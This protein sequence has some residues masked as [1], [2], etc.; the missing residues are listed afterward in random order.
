MQIWTITSVS[1]TSNSE[2]MFIGSQ[3]VLVPEDYYL[4]KIYFI[5]RQKNTYFKPYS[6]LDTLVFPS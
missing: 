6:I 2:I 1:R 5:Q 3:R 4:R